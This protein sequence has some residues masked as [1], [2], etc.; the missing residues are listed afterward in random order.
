M[1]QRLDLILP[2]RGVP[3]WTEFINKNLRQYLDKGVKVD[4]LSPILSFHHRL[5]RLVLFHCGFV[6]STSLLDK[7]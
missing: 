3:L 5:A 7:D 4:L 1:K 6:R 2:A